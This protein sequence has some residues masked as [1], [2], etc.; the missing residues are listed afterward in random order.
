[1]AGRF[2]KLPRSGST[3][4]T[5]SMRLTVEPTRWWSSIGRGILLR[6]WGEGVFSR[7]HRITTGTGCDDILRTDDGDHTVRK[8][9]LE[10]K[11]LFTLGVPGKPAPFM[12]GA[13]FH[14]CTHVALDSRAGEFYVSDGYGNGRVH[15]YT[16]AGSCFP[17]RHQRQPPGS[18][19]SP[20]TLPQ[21]RTAGSMS[22]TGR[23]TV[24]RCSIHGK[25][26]D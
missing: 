14:R 19:T 16:A 21:I 23:I 2:K 15:K 1:M 12:S 22:P 6:S 24:F 9:T 8:C 20:I 7:A 3:R 11:V 25:F 18:S 4:K 10:G 17:G 13:P 5:T 26:K